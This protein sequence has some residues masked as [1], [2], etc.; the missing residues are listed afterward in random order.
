MA[1]SNLSRQ[2]ATL[3]ALTKSKSAPAKRDLGCPEYEVLEKLFE[4]V[5]STKESIFIRPR[6]I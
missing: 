3:A 4:A 5:T 2:T 1:D 6:Y